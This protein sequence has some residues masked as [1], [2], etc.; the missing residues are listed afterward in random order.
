MSGS[1]GSNPTPPARFVVGIDLGTTHCALAA[2]QIA[3]PKVFLMDIPQLVAVGETADRPLFPSFM[4]LPAPGEL[5]DDDRR[6]PWGP[7]P[8]VVGELARR[9]GAKVPSRLVAS[10]KSWVCHGG[11]N[12]RAPILPW[13]SPDDEPHVSPFD[14]QVA[15]L[16]HL[17]HVW[18][19]RYPDAP[20]SAQDVV[21]TVPASFDE[22]ARE[23]T[24]DAAAEAGL[25]D[26]RLIEEPQAAFYDYLGTHTEDLQARLGDARLILVVDVG[27]GTTDLTLVRVRPE[28]A[29]DENRLERVAVGGH[30]MLGGDNMDAA[31]AMFAL[32]KAGIE[33]PSDATVWSAIVQ[34]AR[35]AKERL[36]AEGGPE[37]AVISYQG[38]GSRLL[39]N[40]RSITL[41]RDE[42]L[43]V[44]IDGFLPL[45]GPDEV[46]QKASRAG[47]TTLGLPFAS[48]AA[49]SRHVCSFLRRHVGAAIEAGAEVRECLP[50]PDL[51]LLNGGVF[52]GHALIERL[53]GVFDRWF[54]AGAVGFLDHTSLD[55]AVARGAVVYGLSRR[56]VGE[57][58]G[59]GTARAYYIGVEWE[60]GRRQ[61]LCV[62]P[63]GLEDGSAVAVPDRVFDLRLD[64]PVAFPLYVYT[65]DR[66]DAPGVVV[67]PD[68][69]L[70]PLP[71]LETVL[72]DRGR[73][74]SDVPVT[75]SC[76]MTETGALEIFLATVELPPRKWKLEFVLGR[77]SLSEAK[78]REEAETVA[79]D[80]V[81]E[82][83]DQAA[84][85]FAKAMTSNDP[86]VARGLRRAV[87]KAIGP[88]GQWSA[89]TCRALWA[90]CLQHEPRRAASDQHELSWLGL[91]GW[92]L[93]PGYGAPED[94]ARIDAL[95]GLREAG[96]RPANKATWPQW[97]ILWRR[98]AAGLDQ[99]RQ[100]ALFEELA[101]WLWREDNAPVPGPHK[102]GPVEMMQL[103]AGLERIGRQYKVRAGDLFLERAGKI[104]SYW[105]LA[106]VGARVLVRADPED[107]VDADVADRWAQALLA[108][109]WPQAEGAAFAAASL[110]HLTGDARRDLS[111]QRRKQIAD[112][113][114]AD[115]AP[116]SWIDMVLRGGDV[117]ASDMKRVFGEGLPVGLKL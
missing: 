108:L 66:A 87:E 95:W 101:P 8:R 30:L 27:G 54:G 39:A 90:L 92:A 3:A 56:G 16:E 12:R 97:W 1:Q 45:S 117:A 47:L 37:E 46:A 84:A 104:G 19:H 111:P 82:R 89:A 64:A 93:R 5:S 96:P 2:S 31:L 57:A 112:R 28:A 49:I 85:A 99:A 69:D 38:R 26:V 35:A 65:G 102:H 21:V 25:G 22:G 59:G 10:A 40:T 53:R 48:D 6:L 109:D 105:P 75:L 80:P 83:F 115:K 55:T 44:L 13:N 43:R 79:A 88:R 18:E 15:Y 62:A 76:A 32:D 51:V 29:A 9:L 24:T 4:Y 34:S 116:A 36:L 20:L 17:R 67:D 81:H 70:D 106:R 7:S 42:A 23:L 63:K 100:V 11:V 103:L 58:I 114:T 61:A 72:R 14:A 77:E 113:L 110:G 50:R 33:R 94:Q 60:G 91:A 98:V 74:G 52:N 107:A 78:A 68:T 73:T 71:A 86:T 41:H